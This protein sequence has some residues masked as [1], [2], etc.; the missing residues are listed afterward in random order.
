MLKKML[1]N[2]N[3]LLTLRHNTLQ[4]GKEIQYIGD[5]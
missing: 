2:Q 1:A 4:Y 5:V 3:I